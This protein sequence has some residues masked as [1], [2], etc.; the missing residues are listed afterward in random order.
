MKTKKSKPADD[1][2][3]VP[4]EKIF[5]AVKQLQLRLI[6]N[7]IRP[8]LEKNN[9]SID[10]FKTELKKQI[11][12]WGGITEIDNFLKLNNT[13]HELVSEIKNIDWSFLNE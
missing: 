5:Q 2:K 4:A 3:R 12:I 9:N 11:E 6:V 10:L 13:T 1:D 7:K 8:D